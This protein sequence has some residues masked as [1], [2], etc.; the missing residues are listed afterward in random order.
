MPNTN[1]TAGIAT[2]FFMAASRELVSDQRNIV[3]AAERPGIVFGAPVMFGIPVMG[4]VAATAVVFGAGSVTAGTVGIAGAMVLMVGATAMVGTAAAELIPRLPISVEPIGMPVRITPPGA[5]GEV[6]IDDAARLPDPAPHMLDIPDVSIRADVGGMPDDDIADDIGAPA[7]G[8]V[9]IVLCGVTVPT[10][11][12]PPSK[13]AADP[14]IVDGAVP[15]V[16]HTVLPIV[17]VAAVGTGLTPGDAISVAPSGM[18][19]PPTGALGTMPSGEVTASEGVGITAACCAKAW[20]HSKVEAAVIIRKRFMLLSSAVR[21]ARRTRGAKSTRHLPG[22]LGEDQSGGRHEDRKRPPNRRPAQ[23]E[24]CA[25]SSATA[26]RQGAVGVQ[27]VPVVA[28]GIVAVA[29]SRPVSA[30]AMQGVLVESEPM[31]ANVTDAADVAIAEASQMFAAAHA[32]DM[33]AAAEASDVATAAKAAA[34][35]AAAAK[36]SA[37]TTATAGLGRARHQA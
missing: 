36:T 6:G 9:D 27:V 32:A 23:T 8:I 3:A 22:C 10:A 19:V 21:S 24:V 37:V 13:V 18:P 33:R 28:I 12:P 29:I 15:M 11:T 25:A 34:H 20:P 31:R 2:F 7:I 4:S 14:N 16:E 30:E 26:Q 5:T 17:P 1:T 35:M